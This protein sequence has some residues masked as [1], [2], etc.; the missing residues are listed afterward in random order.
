MAH[1]A[2][3]DETNIVIDVIKVHNNELMDNGVESEAKGIEFL[4]GWSGGY[5]NWKQTSY[6]AEVTGFR[7]NYASKGFLYDPLRNAFIAPKPFGSWVLDEETCR[8]K[9][10]ISYPLDGL[11]YNWDEP[12]LSWIEIAP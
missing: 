6:E 7:K 12:S 11:M 8:W 10:P 5:T 1:F 2:K 9:A 3:L 4:V